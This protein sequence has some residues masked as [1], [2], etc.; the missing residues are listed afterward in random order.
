MKR[1]YFPLYRKF[2]DHPFW[3]EKRVFSKA[4]AWIDLLWEAQHNEFPEEV[5]IGLK[6][7][8][9]NYGESLK[10][11]RTW[12]KRWR[13]SEKK[14]WNYFQLLKKM[15]QIDT[16]NETVTTRLTILNYKQYDPRKMKKE[17]EKETV[18][19]Q[20]GNSRETRGNTDKNVKK[21]KNVKNDNKVITTTS[22]EKNHIPLRLSKKLFSLILQNDP[23]AKAPNF[24]K[25]SEDVEKL[26]RIDHRT[27]D[28]IY[29]VIQ[30]TQQD[31]FWKSNILSASKLR[32]QFPQLW[33]KANKQN[34][35][36]GGNKNVPTS[37][38]EKEY[39]GTPAEEIGWLNKN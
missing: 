38:A 31:D 14:V 4:E 32:E 21:D 33:L 1:G 23:E 8:I 10:S 2:Q 26:I 7:L 11:I 35:A 24:E 25:W 37:F 5:L 13:W 17:T 12:G 28:Q 34:K 20:S 3:K 39:T 15:R 6:I 9:C 16:D 18:G 27:P 22:E 36:N 30:W 19:K 29:H